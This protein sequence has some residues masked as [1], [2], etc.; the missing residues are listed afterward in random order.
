[1]KCLNILLFA[2]QGTNSHTC[3][4]NTLVLK[5]IIYLLLHHSLLHLKLTNHQLFINGIQKTINLKKQIFYCSFELRFE[6][7]LPFT[8]S[9]ACTSLVLRNQ[10]ILLRCRS[11]GIWSPCHVL[12][13]FNDD[14]NM[15]LNRLDVYNSSW[16]T[17]YFVH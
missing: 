8:I 2:I 12:R 17:Q 6:N 5:T 16:F 10:R 1:M 9:L 7:N 3:Y 14:T 11:G 4:K 13:F 15:K